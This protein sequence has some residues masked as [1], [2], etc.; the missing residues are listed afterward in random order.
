MASAAR[1]VGVVGVGQFDVVLFPL[2]GFWDCGGIRVSGK[3]LISEVE[4]SG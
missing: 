3:G 4:Q 2:H 1:V